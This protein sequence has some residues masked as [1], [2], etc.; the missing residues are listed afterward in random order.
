M[1]STILLPRSLLFATIVEE[2][3]RPQT[4]NT[5]MLFAALVGKKGHLAKVCRS[6]TKDLKMPQTVPKPTGKP[7]KTHYLDEGKDDDEY[8][9]FTVNSTTNQPL[10]LLLL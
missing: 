5:N 7:K 1:I 4:V 8:N 10:T 3:T 9:M 6:K 2:V